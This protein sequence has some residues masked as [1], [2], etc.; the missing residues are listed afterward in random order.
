MPKA[1]PDEVREKLSEAAE[2]IVWRVGF[3]KMTIDEIAASVQISK[4]AVYRFFASKEEIGDAIVTRYTDSMYRRQREL[5][6]AAELSW[7][8][9]LQGM[10]MVPVEIASDK[11]K[12]HSY[13]PMAATIFGPRERAFARVNARELQLLAKVLKSG[14]KAGAFRSGN[15]MQMARSLRLATAGCI[16]PYLWLD[17]PHAAVEEAR[18]VLNLLFDGLAQS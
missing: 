17:D 9:R 3:A 7:K 5:A 12:K 15:T 8:A 11:Y 1:L 2:N 18:S 6:E 14:Q 10:L 4:G 16:P 13:G